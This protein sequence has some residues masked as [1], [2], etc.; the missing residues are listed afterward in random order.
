MEGL[1]S[2]VPVRSFGHGNDRNV[3]NPGILHYLAYGGQLALAAVDQKEVGPVAAAS[4]GIL[5]LQSCEA[6]LEYF[7]GSSAG[8]AG[9]GLGTAP[10]NAGTYTVRASFAG[11]GNYQLRVVGPPIP[12]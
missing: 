6:T 7:A 9:S 12:E 10:T 4:L 8:T 1:A 11:N 3:V 2:C 5:F